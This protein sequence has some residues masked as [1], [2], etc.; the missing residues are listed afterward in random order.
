VARRNGYQIPSDVLS[1]YRALVTVETLAT[2]LGLPNGLRDVG[3]RFF[4]ELRRDEKFDQLFD[5]DRLQQV[6]L[7]TLTLTQDGPAQLAQILADAAD[8]SVRC[9]WNPRT[10]PG[11]SGRRTDARGFGRRPFSRSASPCC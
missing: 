9:A 1:L 7:N 11:W 2:E 4:A 6:L 10:R 8:G 3:G 5:R